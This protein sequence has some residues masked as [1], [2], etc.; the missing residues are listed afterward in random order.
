MFINNVFFSFF[1][2]SKPKA[3]LAYVDVSGAILLS[4]HFLTC[5]ILFFF[6]FFSGILSKIQGEY[7]ISDSQGGA[8]QTAF[9]CSYMVFAPIFGYLGDRQSRKLIMAFGVF[10]WTVF[11]IIGSFMPVSLLTS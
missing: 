4:P 3:I 7:Q 8:L 10:L 11:T 5:P 9:V 6:F 2:R 1:L